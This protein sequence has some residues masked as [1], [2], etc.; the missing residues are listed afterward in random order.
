MNLFDIVE[1]R[2]QDI[3]ESSDLVVPIPFKKLAK[4]ASR[5]M[6][7]NSVKA[8][9]HVIAPSLYTVLVSPGDD[10]MIAP[11]YQQVTDELVDFITHEA[12]NAGLT[13]IA[14]PMVRFIAD[15]NVRSGKMEVIAEIVTSEVL[16]KLR[17]EEAAYTEAHMR[18]AGATPKR[19]VGA[20]RPMPQQAA[21]QLSAVPDIAAQ[22][23]D[24]DASDGAKPAE[25]PVDA[26]D[27]PVRPVADPG[28]SP[29]QPRPVTMPVVEPEPQEPKAPQ[30]PP[31]QVAG[32]NPATVPSADT[33]AQRPFHGFVG[34]ACELTDTATGKRWRIG[35]D[36]TVIGR[37]ESQADLVLED[38]NVSRRH[39]E[40][41]RNG[42]TW[43]LSD[44]GST[45]GT[46]VNGMRV[47]QPVELHD[48]DTV[49]MGLIA[50]AFR[51][52]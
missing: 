9:G 19:P 6:K 26:F 32:V 11:L 28:E 16:E 2:M 51:E 12:S 10:S 48:G 29:D 23:P 14:Q 20:A 41:R 35:V 38:T 4:Q 27:A 21:D 7:R 33:T 45:N 31:V 40:L 44:L 1:S 49:Q 43:I 50:L 24:I 17:E 52:L 47:R 34:S 13:V 5:E 42:A 15:P 25:E 39:A 30:T 22:V 3:F 46:R 8:D 18:I 36:L 37:E